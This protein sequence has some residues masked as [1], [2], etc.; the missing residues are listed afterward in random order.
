M[1]V[2]VE[3]L[4]VLDDLHGLTRTGAER[5]AA[6]AVARRTVELLS[7]LDAVALEPAV[8]PTTQFRSL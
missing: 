4:R 5:E 6:L 7:S 2:T 1:D 8:E 3:A